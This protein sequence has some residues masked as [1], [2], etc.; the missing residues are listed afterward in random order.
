MYLAQAQPELRLTENL[1]GSPTSS[2]LV[3]E[4]P[5]TL[6]G[7]HIVVLVKMSLQKIQKDDDRSIA[8]NSSANILRCTVTTSMYSS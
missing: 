3:A 8:S 4:K 2:E 6:L 7:E 1:L 5:L